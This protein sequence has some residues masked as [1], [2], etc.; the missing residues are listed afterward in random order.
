METFYILKKISK[1]VVSK[2]WN[3]TNIFSVDKLYSFEEKPFVYKIFFIF[4]MSA[5]G[6][7]SISHL[8]CLDAIITDAI[9]L[10]ANAIEN[11]KHILKE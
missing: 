9:D 7:T 1:T 4:E 10:L 6:E 3:T 8:I 5:E 2:N 11:M